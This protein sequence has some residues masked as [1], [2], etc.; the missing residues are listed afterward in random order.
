MIEIVY[1]S[2][3]KSTIIFFTVYKSWWRYLGNGDHLE[4]LN[5]DG[6]IIL[7]FVFTKWDVGMDWIDPAQDRDR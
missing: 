4:D 6:R 3:A 2:A 5:I 1:I 7:K